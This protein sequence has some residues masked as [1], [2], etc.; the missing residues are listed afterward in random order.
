VEAIPTGGCRV[1]TI[2]TINNA[3]IEILKVLGEQPIPMSPKDLTRSVQEKG[4]DESSIV[5]A[6]WFLI[7]RNAIKLATDLKLSLVPRVG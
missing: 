1:R 3:E 4:I 2:E 7:D 5:S 6:I